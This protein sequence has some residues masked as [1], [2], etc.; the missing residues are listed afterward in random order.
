[1]SPTVP[2]QNPATTESNWHAI[3]IGTDDYPR[4]PS[5]KLN[6]CVRDATSIRDFLLEKVEI[7]E[8]RL[9]F[10]TSPAADPAH[11]SSAGNIRAAF[12]AL[13]E[14]V[15][16]GDHVVLFYAC[17]GV[18]LTRTTPNAAS[19]VFYGLVAAD[20]EPNGEGFCNLVLDREIN[21]LLRQLQKRSVS[22]TV[23][24]DTCH[25]GASTRDI[26]TKPPV[27]RFLKVLEP[28]SDGD[29]A[30]LQAKHPALVPQPATRDLEGDAP[31]DRIVTQVASDVDFVVLAACQDG[32]TAK[33]V[34]EDTVAA[35]GTRTT[36]SHG[37]LT[38]SL[39]QALGKVPAEHVKNLRWMDFYD[40]LSSTVV[41]RVS[42]QKPSLEGNPARS[43]FG[44]KWKPFAPGFTVRQVDGVFNVEGGIV[45]GLDV[46]AEIDIYPYD[47]PDFEASAA[48]PVRAKIDTAALSTSVAK[49]VDPAKPVDAK[50]RAR[51]VKPSPNVAPMKVRIVGVPPEIL[52]AAGLDAEDVARFV[53]IAAEGTSAHIE[54]RPFSGEVPAKAWGV[55]FDEDGNEL[56]GENA[57][58]FEGARDGWVFVRSD[59]SGAPGLL[60]P[61]FK[62]APE[63]IIAY[64]P[65]TSSQSRGLSADQL[66][67]KL[68]AALGNGLVHYAKYLRTRDRSGSDATLRAMMS[69]KLRVGEE[70]DLPDE[71]A[72]ELPAELIAKTKYLEPV[73]GVYTVRD[74]QW[75]FFE[76]TVL[77]ATKLRLFVGVLLC[78]DDGNVQPGWPPSGE[79]Y[80]F[81]EKTTT[82]IGQDRFNPQV[83]NRRKDQRTT[84]WTLKFVGY[85][86]AKESAPIDLH[87]LA[88]EKTVQDVIAED[89]KRT[90]AF[91]GRP[92]PKPEQ[93]AYYTWDF[94]IACTRP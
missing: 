89:L 9:S 39:L 15:H 17:H 38:S 78:S 34:T 35:D 26:K 30:T 82:Y 80:T 11:L 33:E 84:M 32:Q 43:V 8:S 54:V 20:V 29:W 76:A 67:T 10:L 4:M 37:A 52:S 40:D 25:S 69:V 61:D 42:A 53:A 1:M 5:T 64:L 63:D 51:L 48:A 16:A 45:H 55:D 88:Q 72:T 19:Q 12:A 58:D 31:A 49:L 2:A 57:K 50:A 75:L 41:K 85:T 79:N 13:V 71:G 68:G 65:N 87:S 81:D 7:P 36:T 92:V 66:H 60:P 47:T 46:G 93:P 18:R 77:K 24:A 3:V 14:R 27:E 23:I 90:R 21:R 62:A 70:A 94:R 91:A 6:G 28:L 83:L 73:A 22:V 59:A 74:D 56:L 86:A 44:G